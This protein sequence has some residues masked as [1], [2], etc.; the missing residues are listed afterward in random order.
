MMVGRAVQAEGGQGR[1]PRRARRRST[2]RG[3]RVADERGH[4]RGRRRRPGSPR[5]RGARHRRRAGQRADRAGRGDH[6]PAP[7]ARRSTSTW[8]ASPSPAARP[9]RMLAAGVGYIPED[10]SVDG[11]VKEFTVAENLVLDVYHAQ[12]YSSGLAL[13]PDAIVASARGPDR[14]SSTSVR[15]RRGAGRH[16]LRRQ[17]AEG[18]RGPG[19]VPAAEAADRVAADPWRGRRLDRVH[20]RAGSSRERDAGT[21]VLLV[22]SELDEV[23]AL[24]DRIA[25]MYRGQVLAIGAARTRRASSSAC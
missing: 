17:P 11:L 19:D 15:R 2:L 16:A 7:G 6:G 18:D 4:R 14:A 13:R 8:P 21:A 24:A 22:S 5:G 20:P 23:V 9:R 12:P 25:V 10:R 3:L 1:R